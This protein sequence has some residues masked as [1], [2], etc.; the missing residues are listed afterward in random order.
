MAEAPQRPL[1]QRVPLLIATLVCDTGATDPATNKKTLIGIFN[2]ISASTFP[3]VRPVSL[4]FK[5]TDAEGYYKFEIRYIKQSTNETLAYARGELVA[6]D[7]LKST[8]ILIEMPRLPIPG[9]GRY[10]FQ[11]WANDTF[12]GSTSIDAVQIAIPQQGAP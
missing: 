10:E 12:L 2:S 6:E 1:S 4:Y 3:S 5:V 9:E 8:D 11:I 7:P